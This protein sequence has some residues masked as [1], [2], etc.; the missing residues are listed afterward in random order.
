[1]LTLHV[2][3]GGCTTAGIVGVTLGGGVS[4]WQGLY[5]MMID[6]LLDVEMITATGD[7]V[8]AS[9]KENQELFWGMRGAGFNFGIVTSATYRIYDRRNGGQ[10][11]L[12]DLILPFTAGDSIMQILKGWEEDQPAG[13]SVAAVCAYNEQAGGVSISTNTRYNAYPK[14]TM[15]L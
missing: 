4:P 8:K 5:G 3:V 11:F 15:T 9:A 1:M 7:Q 2:A 12:T 13:L 10:V 6:N 14:L